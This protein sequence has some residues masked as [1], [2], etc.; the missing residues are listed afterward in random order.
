MAGCP[1]QAWGSLIS[2]GSHCRGCCG[3]EHRQK[4]LELWQESRVT[5]VVL[6]SGVKSLKDKDIV[7]S[8]K[9]HKCPGNRRG[10]EALGCLVSLNSKS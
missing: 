10:L 1:G 7:M 6:G 8:R 2:L 3:L 5:P 4:V 9:N